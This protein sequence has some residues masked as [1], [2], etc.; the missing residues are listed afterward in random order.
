MQHLK[1][2][3]LSNGMT[4]MPDQSV[5]TSGTGSDYYPSGN[6]DKRYA[7]RDAE[8]DFAYVYL[9][10]GGSVTVN[11][12]KIDRKSVSARWFD[13]RRGSYKLIGTYS[14]AGTQ[15]FTAASSGQNN[16]WVLVLEGQ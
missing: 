3:C 6:P 4:Y 11:M 5:I 7:V 16:D 10:Q 13:P 9:T 1:A 15:T 2:L 8:A 14:N 12:A